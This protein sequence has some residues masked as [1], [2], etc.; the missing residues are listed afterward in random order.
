[1]KRGTKLLIWS[2]IA[3]VI[4]TFELLVPSP[5]GILPTTWPLFFY[6][7][8]DLI[9]SVAIIGIILNIWGILQARRQRSQ[10]K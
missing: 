10:T 6:R 4:F 9:G 8:I 5:P 2:A 1:V 7:L 3:A